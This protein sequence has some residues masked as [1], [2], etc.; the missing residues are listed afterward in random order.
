MIPKRCPFC[1]TLP[2]VFPKHPEVEGNAWAAV[3]CVNARCPAQPTVLDGA[4]FCDSRGS[5]A[6]KALAIRRWNRR[7]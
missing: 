3:K 7:K 2:T 4:K 5:A 6:Y 1:G